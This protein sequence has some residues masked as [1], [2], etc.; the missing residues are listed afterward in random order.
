MTTR[1]YVFRLRGDADQL[2]QAHERA[3]AAADKHADQ[4]ADLARQQAAAKAS[5]DAYA[6]ALGRQVAGL[7]GARNAAAGFARSGKLS[8][9]ELQ[10]V[11]FQLNDLA[12]QVAS[13]Q[14]PLTAL[15]QQGSQLSGTFGGIRPALSA[16]ASLLTPTVVLMGGLAAAV[17]AVGTAY[18]AGQREDERFRDSLVLTG[19]AAGQTRSSF[20]A[21]IETTRAASGVSVGSARE[22]A[23]TLLATGRIGPQ[24]L[25]AVA[26]ATATLARVSGRSAADVAKDFAGMADGVRTR[27]TTS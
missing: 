15:V 21:L 4:T 12:V 9:Q 14:N 20:A 27:R 26:Q 22:I 6:G 11:G 13:G 23:E 25:G 19:N 8:A 5:G 10:Q 18:I 2:A 7:H 16:V 3:A 17:A 24:A 1:D